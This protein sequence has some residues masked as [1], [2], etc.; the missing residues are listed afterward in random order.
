MKQPIFALI[1]SN[2]FFVSCE[3][4]FRP[5]LEGK[6]VV[7]MSSGDGCVVARSNEAK[8]LGI[9]MGAPVFKYRHIFKE[10]GIVS[11]SGNFE[12]YG[13]IS[14][15]IT[16][17]LTPVT[18]KIEVYSVDE[19]FLDLSELNIDDYQAWGKM[20]RDRIWRWIGIPVSVGIAPTKTLAKL[21]AAHTKKHPETG[22]ALN[23]T[24]QDSTLHRVLEKTPVKDVWGIGWRLAPKMRA[25]GI[26]NGLQLSQLRPQLAKQLMGIHGRQLVAELNGISCYPLEREGKVQKSIARTRT[27]GEDTGDIGALEAA[28]ASFTTKAAFR[29]RTDHQLTRRVGVF[30]TTNRH[31]P[32]YRTW[33]REACFKVPTADTGKLIASVI[34]LFHEF[35]SPHV[36]YHRAG[37]WLQDFVA[38]NYLQTDIFGSVNVAEENRSQTR[39]QAVDA[40]NER[41]GRRKVHYAAEDLGDKWEPKHRLRSPRYVTHWDELPVVYTLK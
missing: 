8:E 26:H 2:N 30:A 27:F 10:Q 13:D 17:I 20:V 40:I 16:D 7:V 32:G 38:A 15:R 31:K 36:K 18:P 5:D 6:P 12:L 24:V 25:E 21:A 3:R 19:S 4:L 41:F 29:L 23:L 35:Y 28:L 9:P 33:Q 34:D 11:F 39:M 22:S 37:V 1:D 14:R